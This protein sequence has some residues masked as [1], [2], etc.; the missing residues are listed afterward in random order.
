MER[1][2]CVCQPQDVVDLVLNEETGV[3]E[4]PP[5]LQPFGGKEVPLPHTPPF[6]I[7]DFIGW[8]E[9]KR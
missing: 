1:L 2:Q 4:V 9:P 3:W 5:S 7:S 8:E 6:V